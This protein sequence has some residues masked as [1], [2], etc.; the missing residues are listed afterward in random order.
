MKINTVRFGEYEY[1][2][3]DL[4]TFSNGIP[5]FK[6]RHEYVLVEIE[7]S[8]FIYLQSVDDGELAFIIVSPF[9]F[10]PHYEFELNDIVKTELDVRSQNELLIFNIVSVRE[11]LVAA[12]VNLAAPIILNT[13]TKRAAQYILADSKY[14]IRQPLFTA[15]AIA[16][17]E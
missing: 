3:N 9:E 15:T 17:R 2:R 1:S 4:I 11:E 10:F 8:P 14:S 6:E 12:T 13:R 16:G 5:G 7:E